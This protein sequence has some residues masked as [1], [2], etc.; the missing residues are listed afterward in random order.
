MARFLTTGQFSSPGHATAGDL[1]TKPKCFVCG[2]A[3]VLREGEWSGG[4]ALVAGLSCPRGNDGPNGT[5]P[6]VAALT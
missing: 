2:G 3:M 4:Q 5:N 6:K 1:P